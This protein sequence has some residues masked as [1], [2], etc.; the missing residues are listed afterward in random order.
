MNKNNVDILFLEIA[1]NEID[2][3]AGQLTGFFRFHRA[4][5]PEPSAS[6]NTS[7]RLTSK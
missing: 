2:N 7:Q 4:F 6:S 3:L 1:F 5:S